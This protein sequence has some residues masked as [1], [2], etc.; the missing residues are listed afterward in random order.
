MIIGNKAS[1]TRGVPGYWELV[2][3]LAAK[4]SCC[5]SRDGALGVIGVSGM[6]SFID[7]GFNILK[8]RLEVYKMFMAE[9]SP[10]IPQGR[11]TKE[12]RIEVV[13]LNAEK[14]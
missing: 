5:P 14:N 11:Y 12:F 10:W 6:A 13:K 7:N 1:L 2:V 4:C 9:K 3:E 8:M